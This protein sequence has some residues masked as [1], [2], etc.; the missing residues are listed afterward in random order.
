MTPEKYAIEKFKSCVL[1]DLADELRANTQWK[2][3]APISL[4]FVM[5]IYVDGMRDITQTE[6]M[7][8]TLTL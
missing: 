8:L 5:D 7:P 1:R 4:T 3:G 6:M 2:R